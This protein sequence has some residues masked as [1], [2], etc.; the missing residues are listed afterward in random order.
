MVVAPRSIESVCRDTDDDYLL[1]LASE[2][3]ADVLV[4]RD[5]DL[6][7]LKKHGETE[8]IYVAEFLRRLEKVKS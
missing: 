2:G 7:T 8:I 4:T 3:R 5:E 6:L 1:A